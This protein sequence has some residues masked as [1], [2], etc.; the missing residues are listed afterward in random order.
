MGE[1]N[2][3]NRKY[4]TITMQ[5]FSDSVFLRSAEPRP[6]KEEFWLQYVDNVATHELALDILHALAPN[7]NDAQDDIDAVHGHICSSVALDD[8]NNTYSLRVDFRSDIIPGFYQGM[9]IDIL[10]ADVMTGM[11]MFDGVIGDFHHNLIA[12]IEHINN[13]ALSIAA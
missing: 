2:R 9:A 13:S 1:L 4:K 7:N 6:T 3:Q 10:K 11:A 8:G 5:S 12:A